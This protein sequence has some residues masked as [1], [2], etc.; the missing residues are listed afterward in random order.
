MV[1]VEPI[2][3]PPG[4]IAEKVV[5]AGLRPELIVCN[6]ISKPQNPGDFSISDRG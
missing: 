1:S 5:R 2:C 4:N 3:W 6:D